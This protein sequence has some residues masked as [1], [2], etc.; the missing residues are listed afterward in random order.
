MGTDGKYQIDTSDEKGV[1][2]TAHMN[3][4]FTF[5]CIVNLAD[6]V[7]SLYVFRYETERY[8]TLLLPYRL[9]TKLKHQYWLFFF[10][11]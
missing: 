2:Y 9:V 4:G 3:A 1:N 5:Y 7:N 11:L 6:D 10:F 8:F